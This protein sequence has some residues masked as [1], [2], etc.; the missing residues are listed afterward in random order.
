VRGNT[1]PKILK[2]GSNYGKKEGM[3]HSSRLTAIETK[4][5]NNYGLLPFK[6]DKKK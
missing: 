3:T 5:K 1:N 4:M 6:T 2:R